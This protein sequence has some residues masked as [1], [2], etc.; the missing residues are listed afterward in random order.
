MADAELAKLA[1]VTVGAWAKRHGEYDFGSYKRLAEQVGWAT[2]ESYDELLLVNDSCYL[3]RP[4]DEVFREMDERACDWWGLQSTK[5]AGR[6]RRV[7]EE[8]FRTPIPMDSARYTMVDRFEDD[9]RYDF[10]IA[11][12]FLAYRTPVI[13]DPEFRR[14]L[15]SV[16]MQDKKHKVIF[17]YEVGLTRWLLHHGH[18]FDTFI[19]TLYPFH[20][21]YNGWYF[22]MLDQGFPLLKRNLLASNPF[23]LRGLANWKDR[24]VE[25]APQ[26]K[27]DQFERNLN[28]IVDEATLD[29]LLD[30]DGAALEDPL[31]N[32]VPEE[33]L[34][35]AD[36][37][38]VDSRTS[39]IASL[40]VFLVDPVSGEFTGS[41]RAVYEAVKDDAG[42]KKA[43]LT[44]HKLVDVEGVN[45]DVIALESVAGQGCLLQAGN[46]L[47]NEDLASEAQFPVSGE[48]HNIIHLGSTDL[49]EGVVNLDSVQGLLVQGEQFRAIVASSK[50]GMLVSATQHYPMSFHQ[51]WNTGSPRTDLILKT[52]DSLPTHMGEE[53][54]RLRGL[55]AGR[56]LLLAVV[57]NRTDLL[58]LS[59]ENLAWLAAWLLQNDCVLGVRLSG[60]A[61]SSSLPE[62]FGYIPVLDLSA[63]Q[64]THTESLFRVAEV[65]VSDNSSALVDFLVTDR[66]IV[67]L[68]P[69]S[70]D[71]DGRLGRRTSMEE[72]LPGPVVSTSSE[73][74][75]AL[76]EVFQRDMTDEY[77]FKKRLHHDFVDG[78][79]AGRVAVRLRDLTEGFGVGKR[80]GERL[81]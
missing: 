3:L 24:I 19:T 50:V 68:I 40:W 20:P 14:Y 77:Y 12:Y 26:A 11:S 4:L 5:E 55:L 33:I 6:T 13:Q 10:H 39:K 53:L 52:E 23:G 62:M 18:M 58:Q 22:R 21:M 32:H 44:R 48:V 76:E 17:K 30:R 56:R 16:T 75:Y 1:D 81:A 37:R 42:I 72:V 36:F 74:V 57:R 46:I 43:V 59:P 28:R 8:L 47:V 73:L 71:L 49:V 25:K 60:A 9:Y 66:P 70:S 41:S 65:L 67:A 63:S 64:F 27:V 79:S 38:R 45:V 54:E 35:R 51:V 69:E 2:I 78:A 15:G 31:T 80:M 34:S 61:A 29:A 7:A